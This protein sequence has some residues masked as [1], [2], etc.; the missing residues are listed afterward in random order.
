ME[1]MFEGFNLNNMFE[2]VQKMQAQMKDIKTELEEKF[3]E[4]VAGGDMVKVLIN[5]N[6]ELKDIKISKEV[7]D[8]EDIEM[9]QDLIVAAVNDG[10][11]KASEM[12]QKEMSKMT[13]GINI[14]GLDLNNMF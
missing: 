14:P 7:V 11:R 4:G 9:L 2:Q 12:I 5:G 3:V 6:N 1:N 8:P 13:G 10:M